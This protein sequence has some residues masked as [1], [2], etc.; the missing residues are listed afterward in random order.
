MFARIAAMAAVAIALCAC[1]P[2]SA[3][4]DPAVDAEIGATFERVRSQDPRLLDTLTPEIVATISPEALSA[5][6]AEI[7][8]GAPTARKVMATSIASTSRG[9]TVEAIDEY[10]YPDRIL[11]VRTVL[12]QAP[13]DMQ[14][15]IAGFH[16]QAASTAEIASHKFGAAGKS[17]GH[18]LFLAMT[19]LS[20]LVMVAAL[21]KVVRT[22]GLRRKWLWGILAFLGLLSLQMNWTTGEVM[23]NYLTVQLLG[24]G[25]MKAASPLAPWLLTFSL[26]VGAVLILTGVWANPKRA[27][28]RLST[29]E[30][31]V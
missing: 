16:V 27:R 9:T 20:P 19:A 14:W 23:V 18:Y 28:P 29:P 13:D 31:A 4:R 8:E 3:L 22:S 24:A 11:L 26:P 25:V 2:A 5:I 10:A 7:P 21:V 12:Q 6:R 15:R 17:V 1:N 30:E